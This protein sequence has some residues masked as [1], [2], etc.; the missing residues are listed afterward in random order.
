MIDYEA[1]KLHDAFRQPTNLLEV[2]TQTHTH[3][4]PNLLEVH[5]QTHT[6]TNLLEVQS[7]EI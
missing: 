3:T 6:H 2:H 1:G 7:E 5:T 4:H